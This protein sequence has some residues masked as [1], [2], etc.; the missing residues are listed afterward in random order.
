MAVCSVSLGWCTVEIEKFSFKI[1][2]E[3]EYFQVQSW[4]KIFVCKV[5]NILFQP[6]WVQ[7][8]RLAISSCDQH[9]YLPWLSALSAWDGVL[10][11]LGDTLHSPRR[12][13]VW[14][15]DEMEMLSALLMIC[16]E[17][18]LVTGGFPS[19]RA[20]NA[21]LWWFFC[22]YKKNKL[23]NKYVNFQWIVDCPSAAAISTIIFPWLSALSAK[24]DV[25]SALGDML[26]SPGYRPGT[27][28]ATKDFIKY[29]QL[30]PQSDSTRWVRIAHFLLCGWRNPSY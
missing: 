18:L 9:H 15:C 1:A 2:L 19:Q 16:E 12:K 6:L 5:G 13:Q 3:N 30:V 4:K 11:P 8:G 14:W 22:C 24:D 25:Q 23:L 20:C 7:S 27:E 21:R 28:S 17:N 10:V 26:H 29:C